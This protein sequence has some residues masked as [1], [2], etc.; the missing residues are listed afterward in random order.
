MLKYSVNYLLLRNLCF[1]AKKQIF[2]HIKELN[3]NFL[4]VKVDLN[5]INV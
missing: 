1:V 4:C 5:N 2:I 3:I